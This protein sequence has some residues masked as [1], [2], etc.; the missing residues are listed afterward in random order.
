MSIGENYEVMVSDCVRTDP[1]IPGHVLTLQDRPIFKPDENRFWPG[2][3][4][5][6]VH[7]RKCFA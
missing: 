1:N 6:K 7:R 3:E 5:L 2:Q 4:S